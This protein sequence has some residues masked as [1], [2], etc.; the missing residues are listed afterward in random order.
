M[1]PTDWHYIGEELYVMVNENGTLVLRP[2]HLKNGLVIY[3]EPETYGN[4]Q[5]FVYNTFVK[6]KKEEIQ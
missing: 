2:N 4:L 5:Q 1:K 3:M 6:P